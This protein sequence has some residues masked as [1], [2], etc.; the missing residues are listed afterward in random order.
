M[1]ESVLE[2]FGD[3]DRTGA[4]DNAG[5]LNERALD[6][7]SGA[8]TQLAR[9]AAMG[10]WV[11][12]IA[13]GEIRWSRQAYAIHGLSPDQKIDREAAIAVYA[14]EDR[15]RISAAY[16][17]SVV[18]G[19]LQFEATIRPPNG[20]ERRVKCFGERVSKGYRG[21]VMMGYIQDITD[22]YESTRKLVHAAFHDGLTGLLNRRGF[23]D[24]LAAMLTGA[25]E[26]IGAGFDLFLFDL[27][28][29]KEINDIHGHLLGDRCLQHVAAV[30][31]AELPADWEVARWGGDE[32]A[33]VAA[34]SGTSDGNRARMMSLLDRLGSSVNIDGHTFQLHATC[35][36]SAMDADCDTIELIRR[37][38]LAL[39]EAK[40]RAPASV[41]TY[42]SQ[43]DKTLQAHKDCLD[44]VRSAIDEERLRVF[45]QPIVNFETAELV[46]LE[47][48]IRLVS[49]DGSVVPA[50]QFIPAF[51][52][53]QISWAILDCLFENLR[54]D[55]TILER[56]LPPGASVSV[57]LTQADILRADF[58]QSFQ[59]YL[60]N[61]EFPR[62]SISV[63]ITETTLHIGDQE[64][65]VSRLDQLRALNVAVALDDFGTGYSSL[66][67]LR[68]LPVDRVK[69]DG[70]FTRRLASERSSRAIV[71]GTL[72]MARALGVEVIGEGIEDCQSRD[73][74]ATFGCRF[75]QGFLYSPAVEAKELD[76]LIR[77]GRVRSGQTCSADDVGDTHRAGC[78]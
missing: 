37:A 55:R 78:G 32:F 29:F 73:L 13:T 14:A 74:L 52:D 63:E 23:D 6:W 36:H 76:A 5:L 75:G 22:A 66:A 50:M 30:L 44:T 15:D 27:D 24:R 72:A 21:A 18:T 2:I 57:N 56:I 53:F 34:R 19:N 65:I 11:V 10:I 39:C 48:L 64:Q 40:I 12:D 33:L 69:I 47:A 4:P 26:A 17:R 45:Y 9:H 31:R 77:D 3:L 35:G 62:G 41:F 71:M 8:F 67:H 7:A 1:P 61:S 58:V 42:T 28:R 20:P 59:E 68:D 54:N 16:D 60:Y 43:L 25:P 46:G 70:S 49:D 51:D 38:D